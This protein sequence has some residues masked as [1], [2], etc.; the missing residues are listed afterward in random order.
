MRRI[1]I[2][3]LFLCISIF[4]NAEEQYKLSS[5]IRSIFCITINGP[6]IYAG[7]H[8]KGVFLSSDKGANWTTMNLGLKSHE[9]FSLAVCDTGIFAGTRNGLYLLTNNSKCWVSVNNGFFNNKSICSIAVSGKNIYATS[10][11][12]YLSTN[13]GVKWKLVDLPSYD[14]A[15]NVVSKGSNILVST[16]YDNLYLSD[17]NGVKWKN[18][19]N[20][21][22]SDAD[23]YTIA[24]SGKNIF[25]GTSD[26]VFLSTNNGVNWTIS[27]NNIFKNTRVLSWGTFGNTIIAR[28]TGPVELYFSINNGQSWKPYV[29]DEEDK[30]ENEVLNNKNKKFFSNYFYIFYLLP[31]NFILFWIIPAIILWR[32]PRGKK[33]FFIN[34]LSCILC[35]LIGIIGIILFVNTT[36]QNE[37]ATNFGDGITN[38]I[39][40]ANQGLKN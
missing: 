20:G 8:N 3:F 9:I 15:I 13:N 4:S 17:D 21:I 39:N 16:H 18:V 12:L 10:L 40:N 27:N 24:I 6:N 19:K 35:Y 37:H 30:S 1:L 34:F 25:V 38:F 33:I 31:I 32:I 22:S 36:V 2:C 23:K 14:I 29:I 7:T 5:L 11:G 28:C 26:G